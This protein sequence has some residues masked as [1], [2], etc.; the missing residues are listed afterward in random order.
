MSPIDISLSPAESFQ[1]DP[2]A[3]K[4]STRAYRCHILLTQEDDCGYSA[5]VLNL[6]GAGSCG[7]T[8]DEA[9]HNAREAVCGVIESYLADGEDVPWIDS[10]TAEI[11]KNSRQLW[12]LVH[13]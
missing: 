6:P 8:E 1:A 9:V 3:W 10:L 5:I 13:V 2:D 4:E 11:P 12:I 7:D